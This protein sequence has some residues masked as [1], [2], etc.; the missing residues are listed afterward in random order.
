VP[1]KIV[2]MGTMD[3]KGEQLQY[4]K[5][6]IASSGFEPIMMDLSLLLP[7]TDLL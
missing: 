7:R 4:L 5:E 2:I 1:K 3:T 6:Q